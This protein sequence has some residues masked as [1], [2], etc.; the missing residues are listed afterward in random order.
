MRIYSLFNHQIYLVNQR[1]IRKNAMNIALLLM[2]GILLNTSAQLL[3]KSGM[4]AI[5]GFAFAWK[6]FLP[7]SQQLLMNPYILMGLS[8][9]VVSLGVWLLV[10][11][12]LEVS[13]AYPLVS[14]SYILV[15]VAGWYFLGENLT[16]MRIAGIAVIMVGVIMV[17]S[18]A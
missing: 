10:L 12:R 9:Y 11:S 14:I 17:S 16:S 1:P 13:F 2:L 18:T 5:G 15:A 8:A 7:I 4:Q 3:L 6:N